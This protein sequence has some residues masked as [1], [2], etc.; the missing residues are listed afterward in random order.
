M[1][2]FNPLVLTATPHEV[3]IFIILIFQMWQLRQREYKQFAQVHTPKDLYLT[4]SPSGPEQLDS[5]A[6]FLTAFL[7]SMGD[8]HTCH[9]EGLVGRG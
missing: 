9:D 8:A 7:P 3:G 4:L 6:R 5:R 1:H 2:A